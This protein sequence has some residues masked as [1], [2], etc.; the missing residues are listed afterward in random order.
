MAKLVA[1]IFVDVVNNFELVL[2]FPVTSVMKD[3]NPAASTTE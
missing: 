3:F 2:H 1:D